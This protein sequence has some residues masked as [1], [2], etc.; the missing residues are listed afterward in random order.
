MQTLTIAH[1]QEV[2]K[3]AK[4]V[5]INC[6]A[7]C[8]GSGVANQ[9]SELKRGSEVGG[10]VWPQNPNSSVLCSRLSLPLPLLLSRCSHACMC[11][12]VCVCVFVCVCVCLCVC[13]CVLG[14]GAQLMLT[15]RHGGGGP[16]VVVVGRCAGL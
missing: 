6:T 8:G 10:R 7:V 15:P 11:V 13:V 5:G 9:I 12:C 1:L 2:K 3:Y 16:S 14:G 4:P